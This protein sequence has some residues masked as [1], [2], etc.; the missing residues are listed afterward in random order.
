[1]RKP[2]RKEETFKKK[3]KVITFFVTQDMTILVFFSA[4]VI[5][6]SWKIKCF[7]FILNCVLLQ[8]QCLSCQTVQV[9]TVSYR[10]MN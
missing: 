9:K 4:K 2:F 10:N 3:I 7:Y 5:N 1:M 8:L 6:F